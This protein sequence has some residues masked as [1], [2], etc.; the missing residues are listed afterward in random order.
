M[1]RWFGSKPGYT[2]PPAKSTT[3]CFAAETTKASGDRGIDVEAL[4]KLADRRRRYLFQCK[5]FAPD[6]PSRQC[7]LEGILRNVNRR[8][9]SSE[10]R[11]HYDLDVHAAS[12]PI[13]RRVADRANRWRSTRLP[14]SRHK[15]LDRYSKC[16]GEPRRVSL[17]EERRQSRQPDMSCT[18]A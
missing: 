5:R 15:K 18:R 9:Q 14:L 10:R 7:G 12:T 4:L 13:C 8:P 11:L 16:R 1:G 17:A 6:N 3:P 2:A